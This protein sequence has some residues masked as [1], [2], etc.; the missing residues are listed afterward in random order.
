[1][2]LA[3]YRPKRL[4]VEIDSDNS[5]EVRGLS[6]TD[7]AI[8]FQAHQEVVQDIYIK[9]A[10]RAGVAMS[11]AV[12]VDMV[13]GI[14]EATPGL[15]TTL[16]ALAADEID[17][18]AAVHDLPVPVQVDALEKIGELTFTDMAGA[19][20]FIAGIGRLLRRLIPTAE[21]GPAKT[22]IAA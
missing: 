16:I 20:K 22:G 17:Q 8:V 15:V 1:M 11:E 21:N 7:V 3:S 18:Q 10:A 12:M 4:S 2:S 5:F 6:L 9:I 19:K 14:V 13:R